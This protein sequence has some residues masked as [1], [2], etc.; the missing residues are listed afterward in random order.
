MGINIDIMTAI[1][2]FFIGFFCLIMSRNMVRMVIG[3]EIMARAAAYLFIY[4]GFFNGATSV[5]QSL[6]ITLIVVEVVVS[7]IALAMI[8][9]IY[10]IGKTL[11]VRQLTRL[12][13]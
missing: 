7:A 12:K 3:I 9:N 11:D 8:M 13:G 2:I 10:K 1:L 6:V 5:S 4:F